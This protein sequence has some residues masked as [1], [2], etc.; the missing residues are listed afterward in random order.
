LRDK[1][2]I[3]N[4]LEFWSLKIYTTIWKLE[5]LLADCR[6]LSSTA[7]AWMEVLCWFKNKKKGLEL[8]CILKEAEEIKCIIFFEGCFCEIEDKLND[9]ICALAADMYMEDHSCNWSYKMPKRLSKL[10]G[11]VC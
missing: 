7:S 8:V 6:N 1:K 3:F 9:V 5:E 2:N 4:K 11:G 10:G